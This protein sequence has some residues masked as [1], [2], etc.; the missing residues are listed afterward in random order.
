MKIH[1][2]ITIVSGITLLALAHS[3]SARPTWTTTSLQIP[4]TQ[5]A[6]FVAAFDELMNSKA[7]KKMPGRITL[8]AHIADG[9]DPSS[10]SIVSLNES[11]AQAEAFT[12]TLRADPAFGA[13][14]AA[15]ATAVTQP[16]QTL[17]GVI[18]Q[19]WGEISD[20][21]TVWINHF[22]T[23]N[24]LPALMSAL[25]A[26]RESAA[27]KNAPSQSHLSQIVAGG[28]DSPSHIISIGYASPEPSL[29]PVSESPSVRRSWRWI[30]TWTP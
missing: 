27:G 25:D 28:L 1:R 19:S 11:A 22:L 15:A 5:A 16:G 30:H 21:D 2:L 20:T 18:L 4:P 6:A 10:H 12:A 9:P 13:F 14:L 23:V 17:R 3:A 24:D 8:R 26:Y 7:G 29:W